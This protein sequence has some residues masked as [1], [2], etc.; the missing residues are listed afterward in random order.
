MRSN[1]LDRRPIFPLSRDICAGFFLLVI[2][3]A[4]YFGIRELPFA[5][6]SGIGPGLVPKSVAALIAL[7][8]VVV[9]A[10]GFSPASQRLD[11]FGLRGL[12]FVLGAV[13]IFASLIRPLGLIVAG[14]LSILVA[15]AADRDAR[16]VELIVFALVLSALS[17]GLFK[18]LLRLPIPLAPLWL[19]Y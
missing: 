3:G 10:L 4:A 6:A 5:D 9:M 1:G 12:L 2:A 13:V 7:L 8:G 16:P 14:P 11:H 19:G 18:Y 17:I 15:G